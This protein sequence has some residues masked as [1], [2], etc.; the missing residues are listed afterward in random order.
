LDYALGFGRGLDRSKADQF[1]AMYVNQWTLD[2]GVPGRQAVV[3]LLQRGF[4][5]GVIPRLVHPQFV[6]ALPH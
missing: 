1:V 6:N 4:E 2:F 5:A 3:T